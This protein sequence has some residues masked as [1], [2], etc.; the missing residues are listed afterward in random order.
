MKKINFFILILFFLTSCGGFKEAGKVLRNEK[1]NS[2]D[3]FLVKKR[4]PLVLPPDYDKIPEPNS[5]NENNRAEDQ[6]KIKNIL[7]NS[8]KNS[9]SPNSSTTTEKKILEKI[10]K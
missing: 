10:R 7:K 8:K 6:N 2:T 3:E 4:E 9:A 1:T 5:Q